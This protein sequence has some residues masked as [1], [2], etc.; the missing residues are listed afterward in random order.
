MPAAPR[1]AAHIPVIGHTPGLFLLHLGKMEGSQSPAGSA[2]NTIALCLRR[3]M[4]ARHPAPANDVG[5]PSA[6]A[7]ASS[8]STTLCSGQ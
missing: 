7:T 6:P 3:F 1:G 8:G 5:P 4:A 2:L